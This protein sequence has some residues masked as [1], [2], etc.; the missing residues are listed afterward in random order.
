MSKRKRSND[1]LPK[2]T[3]DRA[4]QQATEMEQD[5]EDNVEE[6]LN[7]P[8][9]GVSSAPRT[10]LSRE[11]RDRRRVDRARTARPSSANKSTS[12]RRSDSPHRVAE[13]LSNPTKFVSEEQLHEE[14]SYVLKDL[15]NTGI[16]AAILL[17]SLVTLAL[18]QIV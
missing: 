12:I 18:L 11:E 14:Y 16:L 8:V 3:L 9:Q 17:V 2:A 6:V 15:R 13:L 5:V 1:A 7:K 4:R 10:Q